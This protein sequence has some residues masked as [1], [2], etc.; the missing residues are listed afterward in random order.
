MVEPTPTCPLSSQP[1]RAG[2]ATATARAGETIVHVRCLARETG[3]RAVDL[4]D[5]SAETPDAPP[6]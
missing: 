1:I 6:Q 4:Q 2:M 5:R 3:L